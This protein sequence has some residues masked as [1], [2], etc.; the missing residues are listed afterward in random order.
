MDGG[1]I[2][3]DL[4]LEL[5]KALL[6]REGESFRYAAHGVRVGIGGVRP[7]GSAGAATPRWLAR[8]Q[9]DSAEVDQVEICVDTCMTSSA[10]DGGAQGASSGTFRRGGLSFACG[11]AHAPPKWRFAKH[12]Q[13][14]RVVGEQSNLK[15]MEAKLEGQLR[16]QFTQARG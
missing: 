2:C 5:N 14:E 15:S 6:P 4:E 13:V 16:G 3:I 8:G 9:S 7:H 12:L 10:L 1:R 11:S